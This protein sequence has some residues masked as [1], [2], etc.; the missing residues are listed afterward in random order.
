MP[1]PVDATQVKAT[2]SEMCPASEAWFRYHPGHQT[3]LDSRNPLTRTT[4]YK[5]PSA[6]PIGYRVWLIGYEQAVMEAP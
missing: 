5:D 1:A 2:P 4:G 3:K 6:D